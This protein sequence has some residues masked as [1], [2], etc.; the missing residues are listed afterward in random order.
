MRS[1]SPVTEAGSAP[2]RVTS[3]LPPV[4]RRAGHAL[5]R[6]ANA[7]RPG[8]R[9]QPRYFIVG[10]KRAGTTSLDEYV[11]DHPLVLRGMV[12]KGC[13]YYDVNYDRGPRWY[14]GHLPLRSDIDRLE[15][16]LGGRPIFGESSPYYCYHPEAPA[17]IAAD[18][19]AARLLFA[20]RDP[21]ERAWSHVRYEIARGF[22]T[23]SPVAA[24]DAEAQRLAQVDDTS[25]WFAHRHF[26]YVGRS[27]YHEQV[28]RLLQHFSPEQLLV[29]QSERIFSDTQ[30]VMGDVF[31]HL[32]LPPHR[33]AEYRAHKVL[34]A[35]EIPDEFRA[36]VHDA[37]ADDLALLHGRN[38]LLRSP[39]DWPGAP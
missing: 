5:R 12:E 31:D 25:R 2:Q 35:E 6:R 19:P 27:R 22:E 8:E 14:R 7:L 23:L 34:A 24:L 1:G 36:R 37:V 10:A 3:L 39:L 28:Q 16:R 29:L 17:R 21:V 20:L 15:Q 30:A 11:V 38:D 18:V 4:S 32:G 13:R 33:Q 26:S 9:E